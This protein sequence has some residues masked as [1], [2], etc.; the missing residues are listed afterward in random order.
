M[1]KV[2]L[3][4]CAVMGVVVLAVGVAFATLDPAR[5]VNEKKD[6]LLKDVSAKLG[7]DLTVGAVAA[8]VGSTLDATVTGVTLAGAVDEQGKRRPP[9]LSIQQIDVRFSLLR[10]LL[11]FGKDL[12]VERFTLNGL[13][14]RAARDADGRW[15]FQDIVDKD[16]AGDEPAA[17]APK[18]DVLA[19]VRIAAVQLRGGRIE[20]DDA[21]LGRPLVVDGLDVTSSDIAGGQPLSLAL[22]GRLVD[23]ARASPVDVR[24]SLATLPGTLSFDPL[25]DVDVAVSVGDVE[26]GPWGGLLPLDVP[27][28]MAGTVRTGLKVALKQ[29]GQIVDVDGTVNVRGLS[30][31]DALPRVV[32]AAERAAAP[33]SAAL[34]LDV[35]IAAA[36]TPTTTSIRKLSVAGTGVAV[37]GT[38]EQAGAGLAGLKAAAVT[39]KIA[40]VSRLLASLP[41]SLRGLPPE[42]RIDGPLDASLQKKGAALAASINLDGARVRYATKDDAGNDSV[43]FDKAA[44]K[45]LRLTVAGKDAGDTLAVDP[46]ALVV[47]TIQI[48]GKL[49]LPLGDGALAADVHSGAVSLASLQ[50]LVP[51]FATAIGR[52]QKVD[53]TI[54]LDVVASSVGGRQQAQV[55]LGLKGM[56]VNLA[57]TIVRGQGA[58][59]V[60]AVPAGDVVG[61]VA[62]ADL[63]GLS[64]QKQSDGATTLNKPA[65]LPLRLDIDVKKAATQATIDAVKLVIGRSTVAGR[66][67]VTDPGGKAERLALDFGNVDVAFDDLRAALPGAGSLPAGGRLK[68]AVALRGGLSARTMGLD[69]KR[70][71]VTFGR[72]RIAGDVAVDNL[73]APRLDVR[74]GTVSLAFDDVRGLS[75]SAADLPAGGSFAG[76]AIVT[77]DTAKSATLAVEVKIDRFAAAGSDLKGTLKLANLDAPRFTLE[78]QSDFLDVDALRAAFGSGSAPTTPAKPTKTVDDNP[79]G[80]SKETRATLSEVSGK[81]SMAAKRARVKGATMTNFK[82]AL[83]MTRGGIRFDTLEFGFYGGTVT[84]SGTNLDLP[85]EKTR[86]DL[87]VKAKDVDVGTFLSE[88]TGLGRL[89]KGRVSPN[90]ELKGKGL[91]VGDFALTAEGPASL[92]FASL[93]VASLDLLGPLG[94]A[95]KKTGKAGAFN[96]AAAAESKRGLQLSGFEALTRFVGGKMRLEKPIDADSPLGRVR[97]EGATGL[98]NTLDL[99]TTLNLSPAVVS[100]LTGGKVKV[101]DAVPVPMKVGGSWDKPQVTGIEV[102]KLLLAIVGDKSKEL[103]DKGKDAA[104]DAVKDAVGGLLGGGDKKKDKKSDG[105]KKKKGR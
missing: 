26:A 90:L 72:S 61:V 29:G 80:L 52:G 16:A 68:G 95:L 56:D 70:L 76:G 53:G 17:D 65:G 30:L 36:A 14:L 58:V 78:T 46:L 62:S 67:S 6:T 101:K 84:A 64:I 45:T 102:D 85:A 47:D 1:K 87:R 79:H 20:L 104:T 66:G 60:K 34:D 27:A 38:L 4:G 73:D 74:L 44:G 9:Q 28:P 22:V 19:G 33:R 100:Q 98:D 94:A 103:L 49:S 69:V 93:Q 23:G 10:A 55:E 71:D 42:V 59:T 82:G 18:A 51:P 99:K 96:A 32:T 57:S 25:P 7:R 31:R 37:D 97:I 83:T 39:A 89:F 77:G 5:L 24:V 21:L 50:G 12:H 105:K 54:A 3:A 40:D 91:A 81:A 35:A 11:S 8:H 86:Y 2:L 43:V 15:D 75:P 92:T 41:P 63:D 48:G 13:V 88:Q